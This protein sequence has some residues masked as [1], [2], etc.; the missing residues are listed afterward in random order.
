LG[1]LE[2]GRL[3]CAYFKPFCCQVG[4]AGGCAAVRRA[5][6]GGPWQP[7]NAMLFPEWTAVDRVRAPLWVVGVLLGSPWMWGWGAAGVGWLRRRR[8]WRGFEVVAG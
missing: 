4:R 6:E 3:F 5:Q 1:V 7:L 8:G 2:W